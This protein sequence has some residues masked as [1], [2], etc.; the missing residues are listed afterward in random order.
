MAVKGFSD[1][2]NLLIEIAVYPQFPQEKKIS[3]VV[4]G[5]LTGYPEEY[6]QW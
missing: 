2:E 1:D 6:P 3:G 5:K 4:P